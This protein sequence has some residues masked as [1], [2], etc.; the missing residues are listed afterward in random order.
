[1]NDKTSCEKWTK[2]FDI[3]MLMW[4][5]FFTKPMVGNKFWKDKKRSWITHPCSETAGVC[6]STKEYVGLKHEYVGTKKSQSQRKVYMAEINKGALLTL[7]KLIEE[8][9]YCMNSKQSNN[10]A[11][12][13]LDTS[14]SIEAQGVLEEI[15]TVVSVIWT[16]PDP[17]QVSNDER[18]PSTHLLW[19][20][21]PFPQISL[22]ETL[23]W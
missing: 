23:Q 20:R 3:K 17:V 2:Y 21:T 10:V 7:K 8:T 19:S 18:M 12:F 13:N 5:D 14:F 16:S 22:I 15:S 11:Y 6:W 9:D 1:M 4:A